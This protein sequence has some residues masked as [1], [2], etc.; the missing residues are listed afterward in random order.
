MHMFL[1]KTIIDSCIGYPG[2][3]HFGADPLRQS[4]ATCDQLH[5]GSGRA[6]HVALAVGATSCGAGLSGKCGPGWSGGGCVSSSPAKAND[7]QVSSE[8][9]PIWRVISK[10]RGLMQ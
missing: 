2:I 9:V 5:R 1:I 6:R 7:V 3:P 4:E 8:P 10:A